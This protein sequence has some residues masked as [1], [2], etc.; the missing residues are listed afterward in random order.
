MLIRQYLRFQFP[1][2]LGDKPDDFPEFSGVDAIE[3]IC[4]IDDS[5]GKIACAH[6]PSIK[7]AEKLCS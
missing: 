6:L 2:V 3:R 5:L 1:E 4:Q 7:A